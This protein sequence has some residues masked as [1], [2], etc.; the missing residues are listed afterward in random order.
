MMRIPEAKEKEKGIEDILLV[1]MTGKKISQ[2]ISNTKP[3]IQEG[4]RT[5]SMIIKK[6]I[7]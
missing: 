5:L 3:Q 4:L 6:K 1:T 7:K 2:L